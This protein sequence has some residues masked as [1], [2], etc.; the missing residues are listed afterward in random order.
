MIALG[1]IPVQQADL[2]ASSQD[3]ALAV[4][5]SPA[6]GTGAPELGATDYRT[7]AVVAAIE[8]LTQLW[9][10]PASDTSCAP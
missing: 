10:G 9:H 1:G 5:F 7:D 4:A 6:G 2:R 8:G 3:W